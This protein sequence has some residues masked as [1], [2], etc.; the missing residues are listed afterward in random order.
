MRLSCSIA[1]TTFLI[2]AALV[3]PAQTNGHDEDQRAAAAAFEAGQN[4]QQRGDHAAAVRYYSNAINA[5]PSLYQ[6]YYQRA[7]ALIAIGRDKEAE[8]DLRKV[9]TMEPNF[10]RAYRALGQVLLDR[11]ATAE[12]KQALA[13]ALELDPK[14]NGVRLLYA[15]ALIKTN[16]AQKAIEHLRAAIAQGEATALVYALLGIAEERTGKTDEAFADYSKAIEM[17]AGIATAREGR[18]RLYEARGDAAKAIADY[19]VAYRTQP[20]QETALR[21]ATLYLRGGQSQTALQIYRTLLTE[22]PNDYALRMEIARLMAE[23]GQSAEAMKEIAGLIK[24]RPND[25][26]LLVMAGDFLSPEQPAEAV[27]YYQRALAIDANDNRA[28]VQLGASLVRS[29]QFDAALPVLAEAL[30]RDANN[31]AAHASLATALFE[32]KQFPQAANQFIWLIRQKPEVAASYYFLGIAFDKLSDC[33]QA[34]R[35]YQEFTRRADA[36]K[37]KLEVDSANLRLS[38]LARLAKEGKCKSPAKG[39]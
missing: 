8:A 1:I 21:L 35:A 23:N 34:Q 33:P 18:A 37:N 6:P 16:E 32:L 36:T 2:V 17:D 15:S 9:I 19:S 24:L 20:S 4:A 3:C 31:Y 27:D 30:Q 29:K 11:D 28:R 14:I 26:K 5:A 22:R 7:T 25:A 13:H 12:A 39:K 10:A 38:L